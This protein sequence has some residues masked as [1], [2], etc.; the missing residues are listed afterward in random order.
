[1][2]I[3]KTCLNEMFSQFSL[4]I[5][6]A[7]NDDMLQTCDAESRTKFCV[8]RVTCTP[9]NTS[10]Q[11]VMLCEWIDLNFFCHSCLESSR[12]YYVG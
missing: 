8:C 12:N 6:N 3:A 1:M 2:L 9:E 10:N 7:S 4:F 11:C 5:G